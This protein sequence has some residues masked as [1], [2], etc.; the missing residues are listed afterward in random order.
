ML[1][2]KYEP[3]A[4]S[5]RLADGTEVEDWLLAPP[6]AHAAQR[7]RWRVSYSLECPA[8]PYEGGLVLTTWNGRPDVGE[9]APMRARLD[10]GKT[11]T[12]VSP[13]LLGGC[14]LW[15]AEALEGAPRGGAV[16]G[17]ATAWWTW[18]WWEILL[19]SLAVAFAGVAVVR[20]LVRMAR[21]R[22]QRHPDRG[23]T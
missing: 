4:R 15:A 23:T 7:A 21:N 18:W 9:T 3:E 10:Q 16:F 1:F 14:L 8:T 5:W 6:R 2:D 17:T 12:V 20:R 13:R 19:G 22:S 11:L